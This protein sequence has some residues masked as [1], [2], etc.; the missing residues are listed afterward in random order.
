M[1]TVSTWYCYGSGAWADWTVMNTEGEDPFPATGTVKPRYNYTGADAVTRIEATAVRITP[2]HR[3]AEI[4]DTITW[5]AAAK[6]F[7]YLN[8][9]DRP[10]SCGGLVLP[11]FREVALIPVDASSAPSGGGYN[12]AWREHIDQ[13]LPVYKHDGPSES[14]CYYCRQLLTWENEAFRQAGVLWL[15]SNSYQCVATGGGGPGGHRGGGTRR[16]H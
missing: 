5:T 6:P 3:G 4:S 14:S 9:V 1:D 7:G 12:L 15:S 11:A 8:E 16:G 13:H 2:G 10:N